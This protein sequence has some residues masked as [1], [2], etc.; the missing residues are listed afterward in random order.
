MLWSWRGLLPGVLKNGGVA[1]E[2][3]RAGTR[4]KFWTRNEAAWKENVGYAGADTV[5]QARIVLLKMQ[6]RRW[7]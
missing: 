6:K 1:F 7:L 5:C 3:F 2:G 4:Q